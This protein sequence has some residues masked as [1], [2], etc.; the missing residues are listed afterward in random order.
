MTSSSAG[1]LYRLFMWTRIR[2]YWSL[3]TIDRVWLTEVD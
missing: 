1:R 3:G 2:L